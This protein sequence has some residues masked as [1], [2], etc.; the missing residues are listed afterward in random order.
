MFIANLRQRRAIS[1]PGGYAAKHG[2]WRD[3]FNTSDDIYLSCTLAA[4]AEF[5][6]TRPPDLLALE[7]PFGITAVLGDKWHA[8]DKLCAPYEP[9]Q[10][11]PG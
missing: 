3:Y 1:E 5:I 8:L 9:L 4:K 11:G 7:K 10:R 2:A 6:V